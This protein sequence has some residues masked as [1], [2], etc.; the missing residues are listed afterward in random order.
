MEYKLCGIDY[1]LD[2]MQLYELDILLNS[3]QLTYKQDWERTRFNSY[4]IAQCNSKKKIK[5]TDIIKFGWDA[6]TK[7]NTTKSV[8]N[9]D[10]ERLK[11]KMNNILQNKR[12]G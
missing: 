6:E 11:N 8:S 3:L 9:E 7:H 2:K 4:I 5:P 10:V 1:F 12:N